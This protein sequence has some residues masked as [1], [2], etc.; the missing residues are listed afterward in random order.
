MNNADN[1]LDPKVMFS[2]FREFLA[3]MLQVQQEGLNALERLAR[4]QMA[5]AGDCLEWSLSQA[6][7]SLSATAPAE[8][9]AK[10][11]ELGTKLSDQLRIRS[12]ELMTIANEAQTALSHAVKD[13]AAKVAATVKKAA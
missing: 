9:L 13:A 3:P 1:L 5:V 4:H 10:Q 2:S 11:S 12:Q 8:L 6:K 7:V